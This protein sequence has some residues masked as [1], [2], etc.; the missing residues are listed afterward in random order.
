MRV[1][2]VDDERPARNRLRRLLETMEGIEIAGEANT[3]LI[4]RKSVV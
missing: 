4:D 1:L 2:I 3:G